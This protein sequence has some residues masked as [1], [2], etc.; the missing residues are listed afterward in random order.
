MSHIHALWQG[1]SITWHTDRTL[2]SHHLAGFSHDVRVLATCESQASYACVSAA[3]CKQLGIPHPNRHIEG[4][5]QNMVDGTFVEHD[6]SQAAILQQGSR[7]AH[8]CRC[9]VHSS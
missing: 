9:S 3:H 5:R 4:A 1:H 6:T 7:S 2:V 8:M